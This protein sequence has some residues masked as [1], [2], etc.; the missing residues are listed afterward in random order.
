MRQ[1]SIIASMAMFGIGHAAGA[2]LMGGEEPSGLVEPDTA[3]NCVW[4]HDNM[5]GS[6]P[7]AI[8]PGMFLLDAQDFFAWVCA[9][10]IQFS[11]SITSPCSLYLVRN[12]D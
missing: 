10:C 2:R 9:V 3:P 6:W 11:P 1:A 4:W 8:L 7:C 12:V 5:D